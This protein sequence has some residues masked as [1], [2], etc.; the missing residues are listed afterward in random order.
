MMYAQ[1]AYENLRGGKENVVGKFLIAIIIAGANLAAGG[2]YP[3]WRAYNAWC[4][5]GEIDFSVIGENIRSGAEK[6]LGAEVVASLTASF[7]C[8]TKAKEYAE[9]AQES[10]ELASGAAGDIREVWAE[11]MPVDDVGQAEVQEDARRTYVSAS[12]VMASQVMEAREI[13]LEE[14]AEKVE[15]EQ[16]DKARSALEAGAAA[17]SATAIAAAGVKSGM[18]FPPEPP[19]P[20][21]ASQTANPTSA[22]DS[23]HQQMAIEFDDSN[24]EFRTILGEKLFN[25]L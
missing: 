22:G 3:I 21:G 7:A 25:V 24:V 14:E 12:I 2:L 10:A 13:M 15:P 4:E 20:P 9:T 6:Y 23:Q 17:A 11:Q 16:E 18:K 5:S 8:L 19:F 1:D